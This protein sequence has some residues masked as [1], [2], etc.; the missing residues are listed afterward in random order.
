M[1]K[2]VSLILIV[3][4]F[5]CMFQINVNAASIP[6]NSVTVDVTK[7]K[8]EPGENVTVNINFGTELGAYTF[9]VAYDNNIFEYVSSE[10]GTE[11]DNG[12]RVRVTYYDSAGGTNPR[13]SM[14]VTFK[15]KDSITSTNPTDFSVTAEGLAN[16]DA[17]QE[18]DDITSPIKKSVTV[19][20]NYVDYTIEFNY[21]GKI[22]FGEEKAM[23]LITKSSM[24]KNYGHVKMQVEVTKK[25]SDNA[26][27]QL[28]ATEKTRN[29]V[30]LV[31]DGWGEPDG[32]KLGGKNVEQVLEVQAL[33]SE[34][35]EYGIKISL[36]DKDA[37]NAVI[38]EKEFIFNVEENAVNDENNGNENNGDNNETVTDKN[39]VIGATENIEEMPEN[40]PKTGMTKYIYII[41][42]VAILG[43]TYF[44]IKNEKIKKENK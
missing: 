39:E 44:T 12:T 16:N 18:Y 26:S 24:G 15:A 22:I 28:L 30:D 2:T 29:Q 7:E 35:G 6:L 42:F 31:K 41:T 33:F 8:I 23:E 17:S 40:L 13:S 19:E 10:G 38:E 27:V 43:A 1:K 25:P 11:N 4:V 32:Y 36:L 20:P 34:V 9:D 3:L 21:S 14:S 37:S 5:F